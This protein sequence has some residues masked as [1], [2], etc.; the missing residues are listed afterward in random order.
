MK[1]KETNT[2]SGAVPITGQQFGWAT[3]SA[4]A[5]AGI[6]GVGLGYGWTLD[7]FN[8]IDQLSVQGFTNSRAFSLDLASVTVA[9]GKQ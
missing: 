3:S 8:I 1:T 7:Y 2:K 5:T 4:F 6:M 9:A